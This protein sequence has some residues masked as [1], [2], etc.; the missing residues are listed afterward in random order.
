MNLFI[1]GAGGFLGRVLLE[2][3]RAQ[4]QASASRIVVVDRVPYEG[5]PDPRVTSIVGDIADDWTPALERALA[6][7]DVVLHLAAV[8]GGAAERDPAA[9]KRV[10]LEASLRLLAATAGR[11]RPVRFVYAS[12]IAVF[13]EPMPAAIDDATAP[14]PTMTYGAHK[15]MVETALTDWS[16]R[17]EIDGLALRLP[18]LVARPS[19][20]SGMKSAFMS[21]L[22]HACARARPFVVPTAREATVWVMSASGAAA[23][24]VRAA[25]LPAPPAGTLRAFT[26]PALRVT[27]GEL[28]SAVVRGTGCDAGL[29][30]FE[31]DAAL[32]AQFGRLPPLETPTADAL[33]FTDDGNLDTLVRHALGDAGYGAG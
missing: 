6:A 30:S 1:T 7:S 13:G 18:G 23:N 33:G 22:F 3:L 11:P 5:P 24:L 17:G 19:G 15:L 28:A 31:R 25:S 32:E 9:S 4:P 2:R 16:R 27:M 26:L 12:T 10:N 21:E 20:V 8:P 29:V 14:R